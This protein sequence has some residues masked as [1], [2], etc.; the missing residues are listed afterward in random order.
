MSKL[1]D[2]LNQ[3]SKATPQSIGFRAAQPFSQRSRMLL[4]VSLASADK[5]DLR[6]ADYITSADAVLITQQISESFTIREITESLS[7]IP[8]GISLR[9]SDG[10]EIGPLIKAGCDFIVFPADTALTIPKDDNVGKILQV[11]ASLS[12]GLLRAVD[13]LP[14]DGVLVVGEQNGE[15]ILTW[16]H[17]M[18]FQRFAD[19]LTKPLLVSIPL[20]VTEDELHFIWEA[21]VDGAVIEV[22]AGQQGRFKELC[23]MVDKITSSPRKRKRTGVLLPRTLE[24]IEPITETEEEEDEE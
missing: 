6:T 24:E 3:M 11:E 4:I 23:Q 20:K 14:V 16:H 12:E 2:K 7:E 18:R 17:L 13:E 9:S 5:A 19:L 15:N 8:W 10:K 22:E 1:I 21:G